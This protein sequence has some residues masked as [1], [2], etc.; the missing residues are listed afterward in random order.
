MSREPRKLIDLLVAVVVLTLA[1]LGF[2]RPA[3]AY[4]PGTALTA[5]VKTVTQL[6]DG[7]HRIEFI[8]RHAKPGATV[9]FK[10]EDTTK[11]KPANTAGIAV[12]SYRGP[13]TG[14]HLAAALSRGERASTTAYLTD[15]DLLRV[16]AAAGSTNYVT[17]RAAK[18]GAVVTVQHGTRSRSTTVKAD[19]SAM[20]TFI[21]P[22]AGE[23]T[24]KVYLGSKLLGSYKAVSY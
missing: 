8:V 5:N 1:V 2:A 3:S 11:Q 17:V 14:V 9:T 22:K 15:V 24:V 12:F 18:P 23:Y 20:V 19:N 4:P 7:N 21:V 10:F 6:A 13:S 16:R